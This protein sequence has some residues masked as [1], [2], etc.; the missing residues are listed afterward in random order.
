MITSAAKTWPGLSQSDAEARLARDGKNELEGDTSPSLWGAVLA[1]VRQPIFLLML[2]AGVLYLVLGGLS[3]ALALL[4]AVV[5]MIGLSLY[6]ERKTERAV[7]ELKQLTAPLAHVIRDGA[8]RTI[9][10]RLVVVGDVVILREGDRVP[11]DAMVLD[12]TNLRVDESLLTGESVPL[13]KLPGTEAA[14]LAPP[15]RDDET[16]VYAGTLVVRGTGVAVVR[17]TG[18]RTA[19]GSIG[20]SLRDTVTKKSVLRSEVD[21][22]VRRVALGGLALCALLIV[23]YGVLA[24]DYL[25]GLLAA[26]TLAMAILPE[27]FP[28][29][30]TVFTLLGAFR[31]AKHGVLARRPEAIEA[32]GSA[33]VLCVDKT[34]TITENKMRVAELRANVGEPF[35]VTTELPQQ[36]PEAVHEVMEFAILA[37]AP[38]SFDPMDQALHA[39]GE[40]ALRGTEHL[41]T[42]YTREQEYPLT[43]SLLA[44]TH[45]W[46]TAEAHGHVVAAKGAPE[47]IADLCHLSGEEATALLEQ[48]AGMAARGQR[49][50][51]V[52]RA[53]LD[54][55]RHP[56]HAHDFVFSLVGLV[57]FEDPVRASVPAAMAAFAK[58]GVRVVMI[59]G[60]HAATACALARQAGMD[61]AQ[62][63]MTGDQLAALSETERSA[64]VARVSVFARAAP[65]HKLLI[66]RALQAAGQLVAMTG[67]G[68]ND[69]PALKAAHIGIALGA[70]GTDVARE[71]AALVL[72]NE[73]FGTIAQAIM[74]GRRVFENLRKAM[75]YILAVHI[76]IAGLA[77]LPI[78]LGLP[79]VLFPIH[80]VFLELVIDPACTIALEAEAPDPAALLAPPRAH[81]AALFDRQVVLTS[82]AQGLAL[83][84]TIVI[85]YAVSLAQRLS[86]D[87]A[88]ALAFVTLVVGNL[89]LISVQRS[90]TRSALFTLLRSRNVPATALSL[91]T[92]AVL[93][94]TLLWPK[95]RTFFH[96]ALPPTSAIAVAVAAAMASVLWYDIVKLSRARSQPGV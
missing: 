54:Q 85:V 73:D 13:D 60:D 44:V 25:A 3:D 19:I 52:A 51:A 8:P 58:A 22:V 24:H 64:A 61:V 7:H 29:V 63:V 40:R 18:A 66:V 23:L 9:E 67:D 1:I 49:V 15:G 57:G 30:L 91:S 65:D 92:L 94:A 14:L 38:E 88:R 82:I 56:E 34:G 81:G 48:V 17:A 89:S 33:S 72:T 71:A 75:M 87:Q 2:G 35:P 95:A 69:A 6:Q 74:L 43:R 41:H 46:R 77:L 10:N 5:A 93:A 20:T 59:T 11:A 32:L 31:I 86:V 27:E 79:A 68:V 55:E 70:R 76:P 78:L 36:L 12:C 47:A 62:G 96:F 37:S 42:D 26:I 4:G 53:R 39:L 45:L 90:R 83:L 84:V 80:V 50:L 16:S 21:A 28:V